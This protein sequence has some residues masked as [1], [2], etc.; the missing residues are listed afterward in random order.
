[1]HLFFFSQQGLVLSQP[2]PEHVCG[3]LVEGIIC[4]VPG[5]HTLCRAFSSLRL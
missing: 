3:C 1:M 5:F 2:F 4:R